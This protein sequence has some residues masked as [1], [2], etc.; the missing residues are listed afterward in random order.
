MRVG[1]DII[2]TSRIAKSISKVHF[3]E[4]VFSKDEIELCNSKQNPIES[5]S[6]R[7]CVKEAFSKALGTGVR[8]FSLNEVSTLNDNLGCPYIVLT[9]EAKELAKDFK[10]SVSISHTKEYATAI[11]ILE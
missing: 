2:E 8:N 5:F 7:F 11:V 1:I 3:V 10:I 6:A 4:R 9:G